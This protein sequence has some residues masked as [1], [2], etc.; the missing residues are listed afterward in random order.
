MFSKNNS[1]NLALLF[2][3]KELNVAFCMPSN[4]LEDI[5]NNGYY[6]NWCGVEISEDGAFFYS[7]Y[8]T[9]IF[10]K[11]QLTEVP[12]EDFNLENEGFIKFSET[13][14]LVLKKLL[15]LK[16]N[17]ESVN[18]L[19]VTENDIKSIDLLNQNLLKIN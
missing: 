6:L 1:K 10:K 12:I 15:L 2:A 17:L 16:E 3:L 7:N 8:E 5:L 9:D 11:I 19:F 18:P 14:Q 13:K 4:C